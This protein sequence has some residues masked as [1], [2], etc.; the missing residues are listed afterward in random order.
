MRRILASGAILTVLSLPAAAQKVSTLPF[1]SVPFSGAEQLYLVQQGVSKR[2]TLG[3]IQTGGVLVPWVATN[4][5]LAASAAVAGFRE[6]R[7]GVDAVGDAPAQIFTTLVGSCATNGFVNDKGHCVD[8]S[9]G[10]SW[11][12]N[13]DIIDASEFGV[14]ATDPAAVATAKA[15][16]AIDAAYAL[17]RPA[18]VYFPGAFNFTRLATYGGIKIKGGGINNLWHRQEVGPGL[19]TTDA[20]G[21]AWS[22][23]LVADVSIEDVAITADGGKAGANFTMADV[24]PFHLRNITSLNTDTS[25]A[26]FQ[27]TVNSN[28]LTA[29]DSLQSA[30]LTSGGTGYVVGE[31]ITLA[32]GTFS[33][34]AVLRVN[35]VNGSGVITPTAS[36]PGYDILQLGGYTATASNLTQGS[37][38]KSG[39]GATFGSATWALNWGSIK[40][41]QMVICQEC[42]Y[43]NVT[44]NTYATILPFL[45]GGTTGTG[46]SGTYQISVSFGVPITSS[47]PMVSS[48]PWTF[49]TGAGHNTSFPSANLW[50]LGGIGGDVNGAH[51]NGDS[52]HLTGTCTT[53]SG[54]GA[55]FDSVQTD[56]GNKPNQLLFSE[57]EDWCSVLSIAD[58]N[59][60]DNVFNSTLQQNAIIGQLYGTGASNAVRNIATMMYYEPTLQPNSM[61]VAGVIFGPIG[62]DNQINGMGS[63]EFA[64][65]TPTIIDVVGNDQALNEVK[66]SGDQTYHSGR[67]IHSFFQGA[68]QANAPVPPNPKTSMLDSDDTHHAEFSIH[69]YQNGPAGIYSATAQVGAHGAPAA[70][71][72][73]Q[74]AAIFG[75][76]WVYDSDGNVCNDKT[77]FPTSKADGVPCAFWAFRSDGTFTASSWPARMEAWTTPSGSTVPVLAGLIDNGQNWIEAPSAAIAT[78]AVGPFVYVPTMAGAPSGAPTARSAGRSAIVIDS[79][80]NAVCFYINGTGWKCAAGS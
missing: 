1:A 22:N 34:A 29:L 63:T 75:G 30:S 47:S 65:F 50:M 41:G 44:T 67:I 37:T 11:V 16:A 20:P 6:I 76:R 64:D 23:S 9:D 52:G 32:G 78:G 80:N 2:T 25:A 73:G 38:N 19:Y 33:A 28:V 60:A 39:T 15:Q 46:G 61:G 49:A 59:G 45:T 18:I 21:H 56:G 43:P 14:N 7:G 48:T 10:N 27:G 58:F 24:F 66:L 77:V 5:D 62:R 74:V 36:S 17:R 71:S 68:N 53:R 3:A 13:V 79:L 72:S 12:A 31:K 69:T 55:A 8:A 70:V 57:L 42:G 40:V 35:N 51:L 4:T 54:I 26:Q